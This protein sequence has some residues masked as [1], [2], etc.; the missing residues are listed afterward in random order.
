MTRLHAM[1]VAPAVAVLAL[2][3]VPLTAG[4]VSNA[5]ASGGAG[6]IGVESSATECR[7]SA[8]TAP[9]GTITFQVK[10]TGD[11]VTEFYL[12][13]ADGVRIVGEVENIGPGRHPRPRRAGRPGRLP[14]DLQ[15]GHG[16]RRD[17]VRR[18][19]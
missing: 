11:E 15:A 1:P 14:R 2:V 4:C 3:V 5:P 17:P 12:L 18:S 6:T 16:R 13:G 8:G 7:L 9:T 19:P 10:N